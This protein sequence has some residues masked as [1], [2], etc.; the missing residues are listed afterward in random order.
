[1]LEQPKSAGGQ[2]VGP[3][4]GLVQ[5]GGQGSLRVLEMVGA[6]PPFSRVPAFSCESAPRSA[7][8][9]GGAGT[10]AW[11]SIQE[12]VRPRIHDPLRSSD[13]PAQPEPRLSA[14][15]AVAGYPI[16]HVARA[17]AHAC[18]ASVEG[19]GAPKGCK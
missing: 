11:T 10:A 19:R 7:S 17:Q 6:E 1:M 8:A 12:R 18:N 16:R 13:R 2:V 4:R 3:G 5:D 9:P 14:N 15:R